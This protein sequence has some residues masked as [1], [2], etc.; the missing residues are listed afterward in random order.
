MLTGSCCGAGLKVRVLHRKETCSEIKILFCILLGQFLLLKRQADALLEMACLISTGNVF[1]K[2]AKANQWCSTQMTWMH[3]CVV[4][5]CT[6]SLHSKKASKDRR[7]TESWIFKESLLSCF[8]LHHLYEY[9][10]WLLKT[11]ITIRN[12]LYMHVI[13]ANKC[14]FSCPID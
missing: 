4:F 11:K 8:C 7:S 1:G 14:L 13:Y 6:L 3:T 12:Y 10:R 9:I 2:K 5:L